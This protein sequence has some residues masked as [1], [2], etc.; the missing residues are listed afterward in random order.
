MKLSELKNTHRKDK[1]RKRVGRGPGSKRG[2]TCGRGEKGDKSRSGYK[3]RAGKEGG[4]LPLYKKL[5]IR[6]FTNARF[7]KPVYSMNLDRIEEHFED[8]ER[9]N[10]E[11]LEKKGFPVRRM[12]GGL[13]IL[14]NGELTKKVMIE[15][16]SFSKHAIRKLEEKGIEFKRT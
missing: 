6:G 9:V 15:A 4:Q 13:K 3:T 11:S 16:K 5:P 12:T 1:K 7:Q 14:G 2:K 10:L 8:G